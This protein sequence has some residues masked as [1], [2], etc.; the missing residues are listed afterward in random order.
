M[1]D[2][3]FGFSDFFDVQLR[4]VSGMTI[5]DR[6]IEKGEPILIFDKI[7]SASFTDQTQ[8][9]HARGG[10]KNQ[11]RI[12]WETTKEVRL[13]FT[14]GI[15]SKVHLALMTNAAVK[16]NQQVL[17]PM[18]EELETDQNS[19]AVLKHI[20]T[21]LFIY[22]QDG[23]KLDDFTLTNKNII[24]EKTPYKNIKVVYDY[25]Y[26][27]SNVIITIGQQWLNGYLELRGKTRLKDDETG[28]L[29]T[30]II[31]IPKLRLMSDLS[32]VLGDD[33]SPVLGVFNTVA[34]PVGA[35]GKERIID[36]ILLSDNIDSDS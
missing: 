2:D 20:P 34:Y 3:Y 28:Q 27:S 21:G 12:T 26:T 1:Q 25:L 36:F 30:G 23:E 4:A 15:L 19:V 31:S 32:M 13:V 14:Q 8:L 24:F 22:D 17:I 11:P 29:T 10:Y 33:A 9:I 7:Q 16:E 5:G 18:I 6:I 35:R